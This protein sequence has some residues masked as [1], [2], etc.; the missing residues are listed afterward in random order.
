MSLYSAE[1]GSGGPAQLTSSHSRH[2]P[3]VL[4]G[5][6]PAED[7]ESASEDPPS[8]PSISGFSTVEESGN[9]VAQ[10][11][12]PMPSRTG[13][14]HER[15]RQ[16]RA[17]LE[18]RA[19]DGD[20]RAAAVLRRL[21]AREAKLQAALADRSTSHSVPDPVEPQLIEDTGCIDGDAFDDDLWKDQYDPDA[22]PVV[23][24]IRARH[25]TGRIK[26]AAT[27]PPTIHSPLL[28]EMSTVMKRGPDSVGGLSQ[29]R[30]D[31]DDGSGQGPRLQG[32]DGSERLLLEEKNDE[33][34]SDNVALSPPPPTNVLGSAIP[35]LNGNP[36]GSPEWVSQ[37]AP[38]PMLNDS[39]VARRNR[40]GARSPNVPA[41]K[42]SGA[43]AMPVLADVLEDATDSLSVTPPTRGSG[44]DGSLPLAASMQSA[45]MPGRYSTGPG[46]EAAIKEADSRL[47]RAHLMAEILS[48]EETYVQSLARL[49][50]EY[51]EPLLDPHRHRHMVR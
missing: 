33:P 38:S 8:P 43:H 34:G 17:E 13:A 27:D 6:L 48:T 14:I 45:A 18:L 22:S 11:V 41:D 28:T 50:Y 25:A 30:Q 39:A 3:A 49:N 29:I 44:S 51:R 21:A 15:R 16:R 4:D 26:T 5:D 12:S 31:Q 9:P 2:L 37:D 20:H 35:I 1:A 40:L 23:N 46:A 47:Q 36:M 7:S 32:Q 24:G 10:A 42:P 19:K